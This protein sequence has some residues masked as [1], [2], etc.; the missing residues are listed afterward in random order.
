MLQL[1]YTV[2]GNTVL[3]QNCQSD[4]FDTLLIV[5]HAVAAAHSRTAESTIHDFAC[6][7]LATV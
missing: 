6:G 5:C 4:V 1:L 3:L 2:A 7:S